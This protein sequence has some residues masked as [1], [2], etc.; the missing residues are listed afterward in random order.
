MTLVAT[1]PA[2]IAFCVLGTISVCADDRPLPDLSVFLPQ[3]KATLIR[4]DA[5]QNAYM[6]TER[7][8]TEK[9]DGAGRVVHTSEQLLEVYPGPPGQPPY[10]RVLEEDGRPVAADTLAAEDRKRQRAI[11]AYVDGLS[12]SVGLRQDTERRARER[13]DDTEAI[14]D[15]FRIYAVQL[16]GRET[17]EGEETIVAR[18]TP[19]ADMMPRSNY[20]KMMRHFHGRAWV[21][22]RENEVVRVEVEAIDD[23]SIGWGGLLARVHK[24]AHATYQRRKIDD[25]TWLPVDVT[26]KGSAR[27]LLLKQLRERG[28]SHFFG[29][30][31]FSLSSSS[32]IPAEA[33]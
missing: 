12:T 5:V 13:R 18:L 17:L 24:G 25:E 1:R 28:Q 11:D 26:W 30:R 2:A 29:Y 19:K 9:V 4:D 8:I 33:P 14:D 6:Y 10:R 22:E 27:V 31:K 3:V 20:G 21:S 23:V 32:T 16:V 7:K 15:I